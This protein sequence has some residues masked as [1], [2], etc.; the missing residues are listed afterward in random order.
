MP[1][2]L[3]VAIMAMV[4]ALVFYTLGVWGARLARRVRPWHLACFWTGLACDTGGTV[5][6]ARLAGGFHWTVHALTGQFAIC[7]MLVHAV[8][9]TAALARKRE[10]V[11]AGF[12]R[13][14]IT[15]WTL[16]LVPFFG[17]LLLAA[18]R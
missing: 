8:W 5:E 7:L 10:R 16:W 2:R 4:S 18:G 1:T 9:A 15:V 13:F 14:S 11:V 6:M 17:G 3:V 12:H